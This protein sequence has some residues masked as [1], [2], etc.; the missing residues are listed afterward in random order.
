[1]RHYQFEP[2]DAHSIAVLVKSSAFKQQ[3]IQTNYVTPLN[4][5]GVPSKEIIAFTLK[6]NEVGKA[7]V[8][9]IKEY[10]D[11]LLPALESLGVKY[12]YVTDAAYFKV[13]TKEAKAEPH[14]GYVLPCKLKGFESM[15]VVLGLNYQALIYNPDLQAKLD[16]SLDKLA[17]AWGG[18]TKVLGEDIIHSAYYPESTHEIAAALESLHQYKE[19]T[20]DIE[21]FSLRFNEA[22]IGT[23]SFAWD[24]HNGIAFAVDYQ[25]LKEETSGELKGVYSPNKEVQDLL[26]KFFTNYQG[27]VTWHNATYDCKCIIYNLWMKDLLDTEGLLTGLDIMCCSF[28][29]SKIVAYLATNSTAGNVLGLKPLAHEFA[30]NWAK[31]DIK[32]I[33]RIPLQELLQYNLVDALSTHYVKEKYYPIM[34]QDQ[35]EELYLGLMK[36]SLKLIIQLEL[37]GMPLDRNKVQSVKAELNAVRQRHL[38]TIRHSPIIQVFNLLVQRSAMETANAKLKVKQHPLEKFEGVLFNPNSGPQLQRLLYTQMGLPVLDYTD[39]KQPATGADTIEKLIHHTQEPA[40]QAILEALIG[41]GKVDKILTTFIPAFESGISKSDGVLWLHGNFNLGGTVSGRLSSSAPNLQNIPARDSSE[42]KIAYGKEIKKCFSAPE[43]YLFVGADFNSLEDY[44]SALTTKDPNKMDVYLKGFD[45]HCLRASYYFRDKCM[46]I[47]PLDPV[48]VNSMKK[49]YPDLRQDSKSPTFALTYQGTWH[50]LVNNLG[51][52]PEK[53]KSIEKGYH[54]LYKVSDQYVQARLQQ[55]SK[56]GYVEVAFGLRV[57]TPL[58]SQVVFGSSRMPYE[59]SAEGRTAGNAL[60]QSYGLLNNRAAVAF[61]KKVWASKY[62]LDIKPVALIHDAIYL[63][64]RDCIEVVDWVNRELILAMQ[65]QEL[66][67]IQHPTVKL[68]SGLDIFWP[69]WAHPITLP[70]NADQQTI[71]KIC[72]EAKEEL[73]KKSV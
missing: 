33:R 38:D 40:Y 2:S 59:A 20:C 4:V 34:V 61:M 73:L 41:Y 43:G 9:F 13:L 3:E 26:R 32:D 72:R 11:K 35:Q 25:C 44:I 48:S 37:T 55:A 58:L 60:G 28:D 17:S 22:G 15:Q 29:D 16:M 36:D 64:I 42:G 5:R 1:M 52:E 62:R 70:N 14:Y 10:L 46:D 31:E 51:F 23:I 19:L 18:C 63:V 68:G 12:L 6:Y 53:A 50:T 45:G 56:D 30:G 69:S 67:E 57:R 21:A 54:E 71:I 66:P 24:K 49:K 8:K 39:T 65:W 27:K 7:P 47:D